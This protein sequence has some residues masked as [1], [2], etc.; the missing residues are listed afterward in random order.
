MYPNYIYELQYEDL[1]GDP[2]SESKKLM[3]FCEIPWNKK[4]LEYYKR[5]DMVSHTASTMQIR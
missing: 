1:V 3:K 5:K 2:G 4:C